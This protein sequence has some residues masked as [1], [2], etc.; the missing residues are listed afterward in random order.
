[1]DHLSAEPL[2]Q[3]QKAVDASRAS[4]FLLIL[5]AWLGTLLL[6]QLP[7]ILLSELGLI[8]HSGW[9]LWWWV[10][11]GTAL[12]ALTYAWQAVRPL[13]GY[14]LIL[15]MIYVV[16]IL[17]SLIQATSFWTS[18]LGPE[19]SWFA[20]FL[21]DRLGIVLIAVSLAGI[22]ALMGHKHRDYFLSWGDANTPAVGVGLAWRI[23]GPA[24]AL[25]LAALTTA[26]ILA[27]SPLPSVA[28]G[29]FIGL[30]PSVFIL[31]LMNAFG[32][33]LAYRA[34]PLSQLWQV[35]GKGKPY[36]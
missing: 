20:Q 35:V 6:S 13:R 7:Q 9:S 12:F 14:F 10:S 24:I 18:L 30:L 26:A 8:R 29:E 28:M 3:E 23:A 2:I 5:S 15:T 16:T 31:A 11:I 25:V 36:G 22:L 27:M 1:M 21:G 32:E 17:L 4:N 19:R 34:A 33:E